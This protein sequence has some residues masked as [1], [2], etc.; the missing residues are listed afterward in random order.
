MTSLQEWSLSSCMPM[1]LQSQLDVWNW[2]ATVRCC[3][4]MGA[5]LI[6]TKLHLTWTESFSFQERLYRLYKHGPTHPSQNAGR[7]SAQTISDISWIIHDI[8]CKDRIW[9]LI[10]S[11]TLPCIWRHPCAIW[12]FFESTGQCWL[13]SF[14]DKCSDSIYHIR[15][16]SKFSPC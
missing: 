4:K 7:G 13:L 9:G 15:S 5:K 11:R 16:L 8:Y 3:E 2:L 6:Y 10:S 1:T 14:C 12:Q